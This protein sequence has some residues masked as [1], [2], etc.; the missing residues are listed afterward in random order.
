MLLKLGELHNSVETCRMGTTLR[1][2]KALK[3][4]T[5]VSGLRPMGWSVRFSIR[6]S[7]VTFTKTLNKRVIVANY[8][9]DLPKNLAGT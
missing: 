7:I 9:A 6:G 1:E 8:L 5:N 4:C 3:I 2:C